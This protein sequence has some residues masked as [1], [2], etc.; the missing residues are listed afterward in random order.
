M[1]KAFIYHFSFFFT[2]LGGLSYSFAQ[3]PSVTHIKI[4]QELPSL[5]VKK[6][7][8]DSDGY[9]W[10][11]TAHGLSRFDAFNLLTFKLQDEHGN[12]VTNQSILAINELNGNLLLGTENGVYV[13]EKRTYRISPFPDK[14]LQNRRVS[15]ITVD[16]Q[17]RV[18]IGANNGIYVYNKDFSLQHKFEHN[19][20]DDESI[21][22]GTVNTIYEDQDG[23]IWGGIWQAGLHKLDPQTNRFKAFPAIGQSNNPFKIIQDDRGQ[24]WISTW[25]DGLFLFHP[26]DKENTYREK[27]IQNKRRGIGKEELV[28]NIVQDHVRKYIWVLSFSG[29]STY[30]YTDSGHIE[31][32]DFSHLF[33]HASH[34]FEDIYEDRS[35]VLWL[36]INGHG[37]S[38]ISFDRPVLRSFELPQVQQRY[39]IIP[40]INMLYHDRYDQLWFNVE[41]I[42][43]GK[44]TPKTKDLETYS[45]LRF[46]DISSLRAVNCALEISDELWVGA[47]YEPVLNVFKKYGNDLS[48]DRR[49]NLWEHTEHAGIPHH[50]FQDSQRNLWI[51]TTNGLLY[52]SPE[53]ERLHRVEGIDDHLVALTEDNKGKIWAASKD[54]GIYF[55]DKRNTWTATKYIGKQTTG[56]CSDQIETMDADQRGNLWIGTKDNRLLSFHIASGRIEEYANAQLFSSNQ[57]LDVVALEYRLAFYNQKCVQGLSR[58]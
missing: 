46:R 31:E 24:F 56:L 50:L 55:V 15:A 49:I 41:R 40:N 7:F 2:F 36:A 9:I 21:P 34:S 30:R 32:L 25:G 35:G 26:D 11:A 58:R 48:L 33:Q 53:E 12:T 5:T 16:K 28:Y 20:G 17:S 27:I 18:W 3:E 4:E 29:M 42:G 47:A 43:M 8:Q 10:F 23:D 22:G 57:I 45:N 1:I 14:L 54:H 37:M 44:L 39:H 13:L 38:T 51:G 19:P 52:K 6:T